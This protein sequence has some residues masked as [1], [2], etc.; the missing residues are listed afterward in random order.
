MSNRVFVIG[1]VHG[2]YDELQAL[3][4]IAPL[5]ADDQIVH[6]GDLVDRGPNPAAVVDFFRETPNATSLLGNR[7]DKHIRSHDGEID[8]SEVRNITRA[9]FEDPVRYAAAVDYMRTLPL[10]IETDDAVLVHGYYEPGLPPAA[11]RRDVLLGHDSGADRLPPRWYAYYDGEKPLVFG[12]R[13]YPFLHYKRQAYA[14]DTRCV[15]GG[16]LTGLLLPDFVTYSVPARRDYWQ[17]VRVR[18]AHIYDSG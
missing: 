7:D 5:T 4:D 14:I 11:Q 2:C 9:Q 3:L 18:Y 8:Y 17:D 1:D 6:I 12:H 16:T 10:Y 13:D 15:Y